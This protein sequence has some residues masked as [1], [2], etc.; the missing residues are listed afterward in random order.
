LGGIAETLRAVARGDAD[1]ACDS[2]TLRRDSA[3]FAALPPLEDGDW[4]AGPDELDGGA[5]R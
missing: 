3:W 2:L 1:F 5:A 4:P